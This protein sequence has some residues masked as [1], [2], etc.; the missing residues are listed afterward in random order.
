MPDAWETANGL[1]NNS[2]DA[3]ADKNGDGY[4]SEY[5]RGGPM[6][7]DLI[8]ARTDIENYINSLV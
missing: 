8:L 1:N 7:C 6:L 4:A 3:M 5:M 2:N